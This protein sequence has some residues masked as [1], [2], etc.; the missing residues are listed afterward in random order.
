MKVFCRFAPTSSASGVSSNSNDDTP[1]LFRVSGEP[2]ADGPT[3]T[4]SGTTV[5]MADPTSFG[6]A[7]FTC[8]GV[9]LPP[10]PQQTASGAPPTTSQQQLSKDQEAVYRATCA[11]F[12][13]PS[14]SPRSAA[15]QR[16]TYIAYG[17]TSSGKTHTLFGHNSSNDPIHFHGDAGIVPR[18]LCDVFKTATPPSTRPTAPDHPQVFVD[19][20]CCEIYNERTSDLVA[21]AIKRRTECAAMQHQGRLP[22]SPPPGDGTDAVV[23]SA[24]LRYTTEHGEDGRSEIGNCRDDLSSLTQSVNPKGFRSRPVSSLSCTTSLDSLSVEDS[25][26]SNDAM[27]CERLSAVPAALSRVGFLKTTYKSTEKTQ[28]LRH[29][30]RARCFTVAEAWRVVQELLELRQQCSTERNEN[31]SRGHLA[32]RVEVYGTSNV[33]GTASSMHL[34]GCQ[35][36]LAQETMFVDLAGSEGGRGSGWADGGGGAAASTSAPYRSRSLGS[37]SSSHRYPDGGDH[38]SFSSSAAAALRP[39]AARRQRCGGDGD[40]HG[41][42]D[43][44]PPLGRAGSRKSIAKAAYQY[45]LLH[46]PREE[47]QQKVRQQRMAEM[48]FINASLL[49]LRRVFRAF[50]VAT[51]A[52]VAASRAERRGAAT[53]AM[54][55]APFKDS[56]LTAILQ[57]FLLPSGDMEMSSSSPHLDGTGTDVRIILVLCCSSRCTDF[58]ESVASLRLGAEATAVQPEVVLS[59]L[60]VQQKEYRQ[61]QQLLRDSLRQQRQSWVDRE[62]IGDAQPLRRTASAP[63]VTQRTCRSSTSFIGGDDGAK[64]DMQCVSGATTAKAT[65]PWIEQLTATDNEARPLPERRSRQSAPSSSVGGVSQ[66]T[67]SA[68]TLTC[69]ERDELVRLRSEVQQY[70][71]TAMQL[72]EQCKTL[73]EGYDTCVAELGRSRALLAKRDKRI[74]ALETVIL[75]QLNGTLSAPREAKA[76]GEDRNGDPSRPVVAQSDVDS[77][78]CSVLEPPP[79]LPISAGPVSVD[80][81]QSSSSFCCWPPTDDVFISPVTEE[82]ASPMQTGT[83]PLSPEAALIAEGTH[84]AIPCKSKEEEEGG[85]KSAPPHQGDLSPAAAQLLLQSFL[86]RQVLRDP[87]ET[88]IPPHC[89]VAAPCLDEIAD[90][91][92]PN[93]PIGVLESSVAPKP[94]FGVKNLG[95]GN[96]SD[97]AFSLTPSLPE[98]QNSLP[99]SAEPRLHNERALAR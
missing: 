16:H 13:L 86:L 58:Y 19:I 90:C 55:H 28:V 77:K 9:F 82:A 29:L 68:A 17:Q 7:K 91:E 43:Q 21:H 44:R 30:K 1:L 66:D 45:F 25:L 79:P 31:S 53:T 95:Q 74:V 84:V 34:D 85:R 97:L 51:Q 32:L 72:Y 4:P 22:G 42:A 75:R 5:H 49:A 23:V 62:R 64:A 10:R 69:Q 27:R 56:A 88:A 6:Q 61:Q 11:R 54:L 38:R 36:R 33:Y 48:K 76:A 26:G 60:P 20:S 46:P 57:P 99:A 24:Y 59:A 50:Y 96:G 41:R 40:R 65:P 81:P 98:G 47:D 8:D 70:K 52:Q 63:H 80:Q 93:Q 2:V 71:E 39:P 83:T 78:R 73:C 87:S 15:V 92:S 67:V 37:L 18:Y 89:D 3:D 12:F 94:C 14:V 35:W